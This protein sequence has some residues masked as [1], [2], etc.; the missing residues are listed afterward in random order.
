MELFSS[1]HF[2]VV[3][4]QCIKYYGFLYTDLMLNSF[5]SFDCV[6]VYSLGLF[7]CKIMWSVNGDLSIPPSLP[8]SLPPSLPYLAT[9]SSTVLNGWITSSRSD[10]NGHLCLIPNL[11]GKA[12]S[13]LPF[14]LMLALGF[15]KC[16]LSCWGSSFLLLSWVFSSYNTTGFCQMPF[17]HQSRWFYVFFPS[18]YE[19]GML[20]WLNFVYRTSLAFL[21]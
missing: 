19:C 21:S 3:H 6:C 15:H 17:L 8:S 2:W 10:E 7:L 16:L 1:F 9:T 14:S 5:I 13:L 18:L 20:C 11:R 4:C 12:F